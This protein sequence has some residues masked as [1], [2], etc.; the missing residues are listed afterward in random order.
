MM[1]QHLMGKKI[2]FYSLIP[3]FSALLC[4]NHDAMAQAS[5]PHGS[6]RLTVLAGGNVPFV[7]NS[8]EKYLN[9]INYPTWTRLGITVVDSPAAPTL[10]TWTLEFR[11]LTASFTG[12]DPGNTLPL[13]ILELTPTGLGVPAYTFVS[14]V[15][16]ELTSADQTL[17]SDVL[18][19]NRSYVDDQVDITYDCGRNLLG[20]PPASKE[21]L[22]LVPPAAADYYVVDIVFTLRADP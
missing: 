13:E 1:K 2:I 15:P 4:F 16:L 20:G 14:A 19:P 5:A 7:F 17:V 3:I 12:E 11:A 9:G 22:E 21:L 18:P 6:V 8:M 10:L